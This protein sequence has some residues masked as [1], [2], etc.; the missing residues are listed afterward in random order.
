MEYFIL[1]IHFCPSQELNPIFP[2]WW[3]EI[4]PLDHPVRLYGIDH[5]ISLYISSPFYSVVDNSTLR[6]SYYSNHF[7]PE[8]LCTRE[9]F[10]K[11]WISVLNYTALWLKVLLPSTEPKYI[12]VLHLICWIFHI[13]YEKQDIKFGCFQFNALYNED[14]PTFIRIA[15]IFFP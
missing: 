3:A 1:S 14:I 11:T 5:H 6:S 7:Q 10:Q 2:K 4:S 13:T 15:N 9:S 8:K 12:K